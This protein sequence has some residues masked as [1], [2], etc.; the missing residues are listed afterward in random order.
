MNIESKWLEDF[1]MLA[2][3]RNFSMAADKRNVT[4]PA[5][6]RRIKALE[7]TV[8]AELIDRSKTP[9]ALTPSG[10]LFR[11]TAR[12]LINQMMDG[13]G[14]LSDLSKLGG[15][16]VRVAAAHSLATSLVP[17]IQSELMTG[18]HKPILSV[19]AIDVDDAIEELQEGGCDLLLAF[20]DELLRLPPYQS[21]QIGQAELLP[22]CA[23]DGAGKPL[24]RITNHKE[25]PWLA[26]SPSSYMGRQVEAIRN[27]V[28]L[29]PVFLSSMTDLLKTL[30]LQGLGVAWLPD[31]AIKQELENGQVAIVGDASL[32]LPITYYAYRYQ[33]RLH[34]AGEQVWQ[35]LRLHA[36]K[37]V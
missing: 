1:L 33:A 15:N 28:N 20:D 37:Q 13:I 30:A 3:V 34:P 24:F 27:Q 36:E 5:F 32:R 26:Y 18:K 19:E 16:N 9:I 25:V 4:Q 31:Y 21:L 17:L 6:S 14:Q 23:C 2:E 7:Q 10:R 8:G 11:I 29:Q 22:V 12:T 35:A